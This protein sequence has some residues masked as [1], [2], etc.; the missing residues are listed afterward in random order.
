[1]DSAR[2]TR[3]RHWVERLFPERHVYLRSGGETRGY[4]LSTRK[5]IMLAGTASVLGAWMILSTGSMVFTSLASSSADR[6]IARVTAKY[7][8]LMADRQARLNGAVARLSETAGSVDEL[9]QAVEHRHAALAMVMANFKGVPGAEQAL[10]PAPPLPETR[11]AAERVLAVRMDQER[12]LAKA[13]NFATSRAERLR[14]AF[15][16]AGL[17]PGS[18]AG[19]GATGLGGPLVDAR[20]PKALASILD[21]DEGFAARIQN[22]ADNLSE[23]RSL[24]TAAE[25]LPLARP[26]YDVRQ[27][28][29][30]G[31]RFDPFNHHPAL[32]SGL[33]FAGPFLTPI[34]ATAPGV[35]SF[36]GVRSGYG[37]TVEID[38]GGGFKTRYAHL[39]AFSVRPG[40]RVAVGQRI[41]AMGSTGRSTGVHLHYE[42]WVNGRPQNPAR[43]V[44]AGDYVQQD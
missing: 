1:M 38:H 15:R 14:L 16:L 13:E 23:M 26:A 5:Q 34:R 29:G 31:L 20:D 21:V 10:A 3:M 7:E 36:T 37:N 19:R 24:A 41:A 30:F 39:Q 12:L 27:T 32:H 2:V 43:F 28:S 18:Y 35:V 44:K 40:E 25:K 6:E 9:A 17:N 33:D 42:I 4:I 11:P 8:R 22:A